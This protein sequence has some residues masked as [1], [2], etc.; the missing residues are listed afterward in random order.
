MPICDMHIGVSYISD[1]G[2]LQYFIQQLP[3]RFDCS[4]HSTKH[5]ISEASSGD[6][7]HMKKVPMDNVCVAYISDTNLL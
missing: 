6:I 1:T 3:N 4:Y 5:C 7:A 2:L